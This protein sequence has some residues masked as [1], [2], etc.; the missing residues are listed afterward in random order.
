MN[1]AWVCSDLECGITEVVF[2]DTI[3]KAKSYFKNM[4]AF[5]DYEFCELKPYR[6]KSLDYLDKPDGYVMDFLKD[7]D[8]IPMVRDAGFY[9][10]EVDRQLCEECCAKEWCSAYEEEDEDDE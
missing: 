3:G 5:Y 7:E 2:A 9:C 10:T 6:L 1:K 8:R 4:D